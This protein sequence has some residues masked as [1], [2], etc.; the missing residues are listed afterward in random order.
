MVETSIS[1]NCWHWYTTV[2]SIHRHRE[3]TTAES[4]RQ[5]R[6]TS[7]HP[8]RL[9][10]LY[11]RSFFLKGLI[12]NDFPLTFMHVAC[13]LPLWKCFYLL[14]C[15]YLGTFE[16]VYV[17]CKWARRPFQRRNCQHFR[18]AAKW[19]KIAEFLYFWVRIKVAFVNICCRG[20][21]STF[22][23]T[24][25]TTQNSSKQGSW[26][27]S[28]KKKCESHKTVQFQTA[29][30][31]LRTIPF[32]FASVESLH[33]NWISGIRVHAAVPLHMHEIAIFIFAAGIQSNQRS[34]KK[35]FVNANE[36]VASCM[37]FTTWPR[38]D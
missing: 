34:P 17:N 6:D 1:R 5:Q 4:E 37:D 32:L 38:F 21:I 14:F 30:E 3:W 36:F 12:K 13:A 20:G 33:I 22:F 2:H 23:L 31:L 28:R 19:V 25:N 26:R 27:S 15:S 29:L 7:F 16:V 35:I 24:M 9:P 18:P 10:T 11:T 8:P